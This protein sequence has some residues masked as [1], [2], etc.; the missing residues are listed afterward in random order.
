[1]QKNHMG[2]EYA[3]ELEEEVAATQKCLSRMRSDLYD[4]KP[5][6]RSMTMGQLA[7]LVADMVR[8]IALAIRDGMVDFQTYDRFDTKDTEELLRHFDKNRDAALTALS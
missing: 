8:W 3:R 2:K 1:M 6:E 4:W 7:V 5:H